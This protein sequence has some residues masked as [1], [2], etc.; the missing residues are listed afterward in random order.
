MESGGNRI[1]RGNIRRL[2]YD[3][4]YGFALGEDGKDYFFHKS[5]LKN[6]SFEDMEEGEA[7]T[8]CIERNKRKTVAINVEKYCEKEFEHNLKKEARTYAGIH[9]M[10][11]IGSFTAEEQNIIKTLGRTFYVTN[12][13]NKI[14][15][16]AGSEYRYCLI[17]PTDFFAEQF[18]L[19]REIIVIFAN[20]ER[21][22]P[23]TFDAISEVYKRNTQHFRIDRI[24]SI[25]ISKDE[26][27][28]D[29]VHHI[30]KNDTEMQVVIPF[31]Y[32]ELQGKNKD[33]LFV[34]RFREYF[35]ERDLFAFESPLKKDIYFF[36]RREY[37]H[38]L[39]NRHNSGENSGVFG[40]RRSGK[41][42]VL[43]A[44]ERAAQFTETKC[45]FIDCQ[46]LY[47][48]AWNEA[49]CAV[50]RQVNECTNAEIVIEILQ[51][52]E[53]HANEKFGKNLSDII[54]KTGK[55][56][57]LLFDE[58]EQITPKLG[59]KENW[60]EGDDF[61]KFWQTIRSNFHKWGNKFT[62]ILAG[63]NPYAIEQISINK[64]DNPL[65]NQLKAE[66]YLPPFKVDDTKDMI[67]KLG[68][69]MGIKFDDIVCAKMTQDF[70][71]HPY[72]IRHFCSTINQYV[73]E[74]KMSKP[75]TITAVL[76]N[77][78]MPL[79]VE[80]SADNYCRFIL[81]VLE[82]FYPEENKFLEQ[83]ALGNLQ[84]TDRYDPQMIAHLLGY[85]I[86]ERNQGQLGFKVEVLKN[87]LARKYAYKKQ[88]LTNEEK[89]AEISER[90]NRLE[91][92]VRTVVRMQLQAT[93]GI[94]QAK[95]KIL[96]SMR[97][98][99]KEKYKELQYKEL[100]DPK[101]SKIYFKQLGD[102]IEKHWDSCFKNVFS[103]N[104]QT[105]KAFFTIINA[106]RLECHAAPVTDEEMENFRGTITQLEKEIDN[107]L[108]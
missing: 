59:M 30:L 27:V 89:W 9:P 61:V 63:T 106:L 107:L 95:Q 29:E 17:K 103:K 25:I 93:Y 26:R 56:I 72:L 69:Y 7:I 50:I 28:E 45:V 44:I 82:D 86:I 84:E 70:G 21:F 13:G 96:E 100:F 16:G 54:K 83:M 49:L 85:G 11:K 8:F 1:V 23:R 88:N 18:N 46:D 10:V 66:S 94:S 51:Y 98:D 108:E 35:Y 42:S 75:I 24:C 87:Y 4:G 92:K 76:Y 81:Q 41:T 12:S 105:I 104:K 52:D 57:L 3:K 38:D 62:F 73:I 36:G 48:Y 80:K 14:I 67:N 47:H 32:A 79:F 64:H 90:R 34:N 31:T 78:V 102:L 15:L 37:V 58:I 91:P 43:Q 53:K 19:K 60:K 71:G 55:D 2:F 40:L 22:E 97:P 6:D 99:L 101:K 74:K 39:I 65:Y 68:G 77:N 5:A 20:Y 33:Q